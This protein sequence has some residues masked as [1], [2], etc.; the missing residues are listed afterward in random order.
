MA[1]EQWHPRP[2]HEKT[3]YYFDIFKKRRGLMSLMRFVPRFGR[4][5]KMLSYQIWKQWIIRK[6]WQMRH[7]S[8]FFTLRL[9]RERL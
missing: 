6:A 7:A 9:G 2:R 4:G 3:A 5:S 8:K 1:T